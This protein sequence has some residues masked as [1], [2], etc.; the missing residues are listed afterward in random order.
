M[1]LE[2]EKISAENLPIIEGSSGPERPE[3]LVRVVRISG[4]FTLPTLEA[5]VHQVEEP[6]GFFFNQS[7]SDGKDWFRET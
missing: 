3:E 6:S 4:F 5:M 7:L 2:E 1:D